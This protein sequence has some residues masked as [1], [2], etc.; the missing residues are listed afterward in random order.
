VIGLRNKNRK[1][2]AENAS[3]Q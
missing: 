1:M 3:L 2:M